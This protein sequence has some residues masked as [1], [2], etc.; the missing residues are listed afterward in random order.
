MAEID[1]RNASGL[2]VDALLGTLGRID[3]DIADNIHDD[4]YGDLFVTTQENDQL[5]GIASEKNANAIFKYNAMSAQTQKDIAAIEQRSRQSA[6]IR[7]EQW[8]IRQARQQQKLIDFRMTNP[9]Y[10]APAG[11]SQFNNNVESFIDFRKH[12]KSQLIEKLNLSPN[13]KDGTWTDLALWAGAAVINESW[14]G[15][16]FLGKSVLN[17]F[18]LGF[19]NDE[20]SPLSSGYHSLIGENTLFGRPTTIAGAIGYEAGEVG[21]YIIDPLAAVGVV[22]KLSKF[23]VDLNFNKRYSTQGD[24]IFVNQ[25]NYLSQLNSGV[26][27]E[28]TFVRTVTPEMSERFKDMG[29]LDPRSNKILPLKVGEKIHVDHIFPT[30]EIIGLP[31]FK[32]LTKPQMESI[33]QD[34]IGFGNLQPLPSSLNQSKG[35]KLNWKFYKKQEINK[36][37]SV[38]LRELQD[39]IRRDIRQQISIYNKINGQ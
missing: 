31:G 2:A 25:T 9:V 32:N 21:S 20:L 34:T 6:Q 7:A 12:Q 29:Y 5:A 33:L 19:K 36:D 30:K 17:G 4:F 18:T 13:A 3:Q 14:Q 15:V 23:D 39:Q 1:A 28:G 35:A 16:Q 10:R 26:Y 22:G 8:D 27:V 24:I 11:F 37:Y 38:D